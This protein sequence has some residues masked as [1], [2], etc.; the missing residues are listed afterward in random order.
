[1][2][3]KS[4]IVQ[5]HGSSIF[6]AVL[7]TNLDQ[8]LMQ[9]TNSSRNVLNIDVYMGYVLQWNRRILI[10]SNKSLKMAVQLR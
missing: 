6:K 10:S 4:F 9:K 8:Y 1:M 7:S 5:A 2:A 3:V